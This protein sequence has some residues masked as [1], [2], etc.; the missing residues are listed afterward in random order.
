MALTISQLKVKLQ[1][2][3]GEKERVDTILSH[4]ADRAV[5]QE[6]L[7]VDNVVVTQDHESFAVHYALYQNGVVVCKTKFDEDTSL[8]DRVTALRVLMRM[9]HGNDSETKGGGTP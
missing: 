5:L 6:I 2:E 9:Q 4:Y 8:E 3:V 7:E 1:T